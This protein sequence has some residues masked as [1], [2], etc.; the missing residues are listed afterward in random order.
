MA[1]VA[2]TDLPGEYAKPGK[3]RRIGFVE[4]H[5]AMAVG[6]AAILSQQ[7]DLTVVALAPTVPELLSQTTEMD[8]AILD[9][10]L[11]DGS[12]PRAN[13]ELLRRHGID[14]LVYTTGTTGDW[15]DLV[16]SAARAGVL[17]VAL[18]NEP[19]DLTIA[20]IRAA[21]SGRQ[22]A[23]MAW[24][25]AIDT[26]P[27]LPRIDLPPRQRQVLELYA[28]GETAGA[29]ARKLGLSDHTVNDYLARI[30]RRY[31]EAGRPVR[32]RIDLYR[33]AAKDGF[34]KGDRP[35]SE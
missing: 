30:R 12:S 4:D 17:G 1:G 19:I 35:S 24:A 7:P 16:R 10:R 14:C 25:A 23:T 8:L 9:L 6:L 27:A 32:S 2:V 20:M 11:P 13:V 26:D 31:A 33:E 28:N 3:V 15:R 22:V 5:Q 18:K 21:A 34:V 29:V